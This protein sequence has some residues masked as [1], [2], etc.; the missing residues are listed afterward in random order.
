[1]IK[2]A[3]LPIGT[4]VALGAVCA[5]RAFVLIIAGVAAVTGFGRMW[6][7]VSSAVTPSTRRRAMFT[8]QREICVAIVIERCSLP[9]G[10]GVTGCTIR[11]A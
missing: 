8:N 4:V 7:C 6:P 11:A 2:L 10:R 5:V 9:A 1:V 3:L